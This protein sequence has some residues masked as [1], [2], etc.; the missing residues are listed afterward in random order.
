MSFMTKGIWKKKKKIQLF[1]VRKHNFPIDT[2]DLSSDYSHEENFCR[3][4]APVG[5]EEI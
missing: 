2:I 5:E 4:F 1:Q 3:L